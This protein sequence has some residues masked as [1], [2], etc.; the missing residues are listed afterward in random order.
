MSAT[1]LWRG[2]SLAAGLALLPLGAAA[3]QVGSVTGQVRDAATAQPLSS[4]Q[5]QI[6]SSEQ[7]GLTNA[8]GRFLIN[9]VPVGAQ[10]LR[11]VV[12]GYADRVI[13]VTVTAGGVAEVTVD[14]TSEAISMDEIV[15][16]ATGEQRTRQL[17]NKVSQLDAADI[18][19]GAPVTTVSDLLV[20]KSA[21]VQIIGSAG[22]TGTGSRIRIRG[23]SSISLSNEPV[24]IVDGIRVESGAN[25]GSVGVG[26]QVPSRLNDINPED[27]ESIEI[28]RGPSAA[29]LY[30]TDAANGVIRITTKR[31]Q[32]GSAS[33]GVYA[34][35]GIIQDNNTYPSN[36]G[37]AP[38]ADTCFA[39]QT[40]E[41]CTQSLSDWNPLEESISTPFKTGNRQQYGV[42]ITGGTERLNYFVSGEWETELGV[43]G[44]PEFDDANLLET[45]GAE[46]YADL[47]ES[48]FEPNSL[49]RL[50]LR[51]NFG[52]QISETLSFSARTGYVASDLQ[53]PNN[54]N[55]VLGLLPSALLGTN[56]GTADGDYGYGFFLPSEVNF[57]NVEQEVRRFTGSGA[58]DW[59]P[60]EWLSARATVG[61]DQVSRTDIQNIPRERIFF[62][63]T[64]PLGFREVNSARITNYTVDASASANF[65][66]TD[67]LTSRTTLGTQY[68]SSL[69][70]RADANGAD[71]VSGCNS[72][73]CTSAEFGVFETTTESRTLGLFVDQ[74][75]GINDRLFVNAAVRMDDNSAFGADFDA[76]VYPKVGVSWVLSEE[77]FFPEFDALSSLRLRA[78]WGASGAQPGPTDALRFF[79]ATAVTVDGQDVAGVT[80]GELGN[81]DL[82][83]EQSSEIEAGFD[84]G[85]I[86]DRINLNVT[87]YAKKT[88]DLL[89]EQPLPPS[90]GVGDDRF[91]NLGEVTN[92][93]WELGLDARII[94]TPT[95][96]WD[97]GVQFATNDNELVDLGDLPN[98]EPIPD[99][100][101]GVQWFVEGYPMG[102]YWDFPM[103]YDDANGDGIIDLDE[104]T[105][106]DEE[107]FLGSAIPTRDLSLSTGITLFNMVRI[108]ALAD[109]R[110]GHKLR[111]LTESFRCGFGICEG[112]YN[113]DAS[114]KDQ[115]RALTQTFT[116][117]AT[118]DGFIEDAS[119]VKLRELGAT[120]FFPEN[121]ASA[122]GATRASLTAT[123]RNLFTITD[124]SGVDPEVNQ[125]GQANFLI[126]D[127]LTQPPVRTFVFRVN[128][129]F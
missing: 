2:L 72:L 97:F 42:N 35:T 48:V 86:E 12:I 56:D 39:F 29:T 46:A 22:T 116:D 34:E 6:V 103:T 73:Q 88:T 27:I 51:A 40:P 95:V 54:D 93:G 77:G 76:I 52:G 33:F 112:L 47:P 57:Q 13:D 65:Q 107:V 45:S 125:F 114:L 126:R 101:Q 85:L 87:Y 127:F 110:G 64:R 115:A 69:F 37:F 25:S 7:G 19:Q 128:L 80:I 9:R 55:N 96:L 11:V 123:A 71:M 102:G 38:D 66:L 43:L 79:N 10:Q 14:M 53:L 89:I 75:F 23:S 8:N 117:D 16:T 104:V 28:V 90:G 109:Y 61:V 91:V 30:G 44:L 58:L 92:K 99:I 100:K 124:Y 108:N 62:G 15:I 98:G 118:E 113:T 82:E 36:Y 83:P 94:Q 63:A 5:V 17:A 67:M 41:G 105:V 84:L 129:N 21:G 70:T 122:F 81:P 60:V 20:G 111:N 3:Q 31:G 26:G 68:V 59:A 4:A 74:E 106:G 18:A 121:W 1:G 119:F 32:L 24:I 78:A 50:S 49:D 120:F